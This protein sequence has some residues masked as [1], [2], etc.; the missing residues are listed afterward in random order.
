M[1]EKNSE[2]VEAIILSL[3]SQRLRQIHGV[4]IKK[5]PLTARE[6]AE[7]LGDVNLSDSIRATI[8]KYGEGVIERVD[9]NTPY[10]YYVKGFAIHAN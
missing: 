1:R 8:Y 9:D 6:I 10:R 4:L 7:E 2:T 5:Y 3:N